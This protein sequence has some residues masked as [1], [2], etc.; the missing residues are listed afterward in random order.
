MNEWIKQNASYNK[1]IIS[2]F[3]GLLSFLALQIYNKVD[4]MPGKFVG[5]E[6]YLNDQIRIRDQYTTDQKRMEKTIGEIQQDVKEI[7]RALK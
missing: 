6:R 1:I 3:V 5:I 2:L 4:A 7:L